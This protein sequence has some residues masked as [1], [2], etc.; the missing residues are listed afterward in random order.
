MCGA[1]FLETF[2]LHFPEG[3]LIKGRDVHP[4]KIES[5]GFSLIANPLERDFRFLSSGRFGYGEVCGAGRKVWLVVLGAGLQDKRR[6][7]LSGGQG[8]RRLRGVS[9]QSET[10]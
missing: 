2:A 5:G 6:V 10:W 1:S 3:F 8:Y 9:V 4:L 7:F